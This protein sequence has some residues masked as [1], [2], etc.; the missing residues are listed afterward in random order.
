MKSGVSVEVGSELV[1]PILEA[2][3]HTAIVNQLGNK[4]NLIGEIISRMLSTKVDHKGKPEQYSSNSSIP[5]IEFL[6]RKAITSCAR[7]AVESWVDSKKAEI[8]AEIERQMNKKTKTISKMLVD[9]FAESVKSDYS[10]KFDI[11]FDAKTKY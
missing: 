11:R 5:L 9:G 6:S 1:K 3:I 2:E 8:Q 10:M 7:S 4:Q